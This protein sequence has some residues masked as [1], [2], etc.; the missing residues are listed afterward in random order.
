MLSEPGKDG[1]P[2]AR[3]MLTTFLSRHFLG[4]CWRLALLSIPLTFRT[5]KIYGII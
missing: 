1:L 2:N 3:V 5:R 4:K